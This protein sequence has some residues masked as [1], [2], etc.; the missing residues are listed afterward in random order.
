MIVNGILIDGT[1]CSGEVTIPDGVTNI[2]NYT[3]RNCTGLTSIK[4]PKNVT[5]IGKNAFDGCTDLKEVLLE[6]G[7]TLTSESLGVDASI[8]KTYWN[9][10]DLT[11]TL[12]A[13]GTLTISGKGA[14]KNYDANNSPVAQKTDSVKKVVIQ[15]GVTSIGDYAFF[16]CSNLTDITIPESVTSI[17]EC[18]F[19]NCSSL[20]DITIP[21]SVTS[22]GECAFQGCS[23]LTSIE[24]PSSV[25]SIGDCLLYTSPSPRD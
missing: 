23:S 17:E 10:G 11:W 1:T 5:S 25:T 16:D 19:Q 13:D 21:G 15:E 6:N 7:S 2:G 3:F 22:I 12:T 14:M 18:A 4:I 8:I 20:T 24:I 9:E